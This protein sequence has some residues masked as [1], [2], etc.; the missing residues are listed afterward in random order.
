MESRGPQIPSRRTYRPGSTD[1]RWPVSTGWWLPAAIAHSPVPKM[2][3]AKVGA[4]ASAYLVGAASGTPM[5]GYLTDILGR[6]RLFSITVA[7]SICGPPAPGAA[8][9]G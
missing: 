5:F 2:S 4:S 6:K 3:A 9:L 7:R 8:G 1:F